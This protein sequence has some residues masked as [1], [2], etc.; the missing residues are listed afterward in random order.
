MNQKILTS[1]LLLL[2]CGSVAAEPHKQTAAAANRRAG[3]KTQKA[4]ARSK[5]PSAEERPVK[6]P[7]AKEPPANELFGAAPGPAPLAARAIGSYARGCL[8]GA[9][10]LP[11]NG[12][13]WQVMRLSRNR[14]WGTPQL[15]DFLE[16][17]SS[18]ARALDG[19]PGLLVGDM[20]QPRGG[21]MITGHSSHQIGLDVDI[22]LTSMPDR[23]LTP[24]ERENMMAVSM[25]K[26]PFTVD[27][28]KWT[29]LHTKL[30]KRAA[31]YSEVA[32]IF[33]HPA[34]KKLLCDQAGN[35]RA[36]LAK[37]RPWWNHYYHFH[38]RVACPP[39]DSDCEPQKPPSGDDGCGQELS[40]WYAMLKKA[41]I[42]GAGQAAT[43]VPRKSSLTMSKLP[44][45][46]GTVLTSGGFE[47]P[48]PVN[49]DNLPQPVLKA[50]ASKETGPP[51]P[52]LDPA[53]RRALIASSSEMSR[54]ER[55][56]R[57]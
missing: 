14:N 9:V 56:P 54:P 39:E 4:E 21:P 34:I 25:L 36:W 57:R 5:E 18:D 17:F 11:I 32:R 20:S 45:E 47:P 31:S 22:W 10:A 49:A 29:P 40:T 15:L 13:D 6:E 12:P 50:L 53:A 37:V 52:K 43:G 33:V 7:P 41:A 16:K 8:A 46:C 30:I 55:N 42:A 1:L 38:V 2:I 35:D 24:A 23:I 44:Q 19:W 26:D 51:P 27:P 48:I 28:D 3:A